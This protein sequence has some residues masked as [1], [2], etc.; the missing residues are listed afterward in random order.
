MGQLGAGEYVYEYPHKDRWVCARG[1][2]SSLHC[3]TNGT[4]KG[5]PTQKTCLLYNCV[6][7]MLT[8]FILLAHMI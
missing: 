4:T 3:D 2:S 7:R 1:A 8:C 6:C 5:S